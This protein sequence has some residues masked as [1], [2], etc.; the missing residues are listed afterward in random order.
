MAAAA[1][2][3]SSRATSSIISYFDTIGTVPGEDQG[4]L[5]VLCGRAGRIHIPNIVRL[6][7]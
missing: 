3:G 2:T 7:L 1:A 5:G 4:S 6:S